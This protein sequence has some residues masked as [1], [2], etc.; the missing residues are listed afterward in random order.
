M[1]IEFA[2]IVKNARQAKIK[3]HDKVPVFPFPF[4][5]I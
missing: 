2:K 5:K 1:M 4:R 3:K